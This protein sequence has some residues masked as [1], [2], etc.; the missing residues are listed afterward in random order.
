MI[1]HTVRDKYNASKIWIITKTPCR[2]Y[3]LEQR[4]EY[5]DRKTGNKVAYRSGFSCRRGLTDIQNTLKF[6][7]LEW[8]K[9]WRPTEEL[10]W[11]CAWEEFNNA[12]L[13][14]GRDAWQSKT[15]LKRMESAKKRCLALCDGIGEREFYG[16]LLEVKR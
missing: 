3:N 13:D 12:E 10:R 16:K 4:I 9:E 11:H 7:D 6:S 2:H 8:M 15:A 14:R 5:T 1:S